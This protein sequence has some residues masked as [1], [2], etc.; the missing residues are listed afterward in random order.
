MCLQQSRRDLSHN[1]LTYAY[2]HFRCPPTV[3]EAL[4]KRR[5]KVQT[6]LEHVNSMKKV[7]TDLRD[8]HIDDTPTLDDMNDVSMDDTVFVPLPPPNEH[9]GPVFD[10]LTNQQPRPSASTLDA[11]ATIMS[12]RAKIFATPIRPVRGTS[13]RVGVK[14]IRFHLFTT[15]TCQQAQ[16]AW[17][18]H[19]RRPNILAHTAGGDVAAP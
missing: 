15:A 7:A 8:T 14:L 6:R 9:D 3:R 4:E 13:L 19:D 5:S 17:R 18:S 11:Q 2:V 16:P 12:T 10:T 1:R